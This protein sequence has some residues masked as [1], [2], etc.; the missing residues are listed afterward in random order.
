[1]AAN[2]AQSKIKDFVNSNTFQQA[3]F[4]TIVIVV[5]STIFWYQY[6]EWKKV[7][8]SFQKAR[9]A[10]VCPDYWENVG[11]GKNKTQVCKNVK[12]IGRCNIT[13]ETKDFGVD[14]YKDPVA[15][16]KW[17]KYCDAPWE[18]ISHLCADVN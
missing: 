13:D 2:T 11:D 17:S 4:F 1:M 7:Q 8:D 15:K 14:L 16:C 10:N 6:R 9:I 18:G 5:I 3:L 12:K